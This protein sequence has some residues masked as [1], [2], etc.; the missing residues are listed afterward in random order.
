[1]ST[2]NIPFA[3][4][5]EHDETLGAKKVKIVGDPLEV[6]VNLSDKIQ[7]E[8]IDHSGNSLIGQKAK[9]GSLPVVLPS[10]STMETDIATIKADI[11]LI[12][13]YTATPTA[14]G[15]GTKTVAA[16]ITPE[17][18]TADQACRGV[19]I[20]PLTT[21]TGAVYYGFSATAPNGVASAGSFIPVS[22]LNKIYIRVAVNGEGVSYS[23]IV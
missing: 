14:G 16:S 6:S 20:T 11:A 19:V 17:V 5:I 3:S 12:K 4:S 8:L 9:A 1:M 18:L 13:S 2:K 15:D 21:N 7:S 22:N 23:Y 10:D